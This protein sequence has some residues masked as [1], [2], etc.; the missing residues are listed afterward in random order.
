MGGLTRA[1]VAG[2]L[3]LTL[4]ACSDSSAG[5]PRRTVPPSVGPSLPAV[6]ALAL[7]TVRTPAGDDASPFNK[8]RQLSAPPG[9]KVTAKVSNPPTTYK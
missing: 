7:T 2:G 1:V 5:A 6:P 3:A 4:A 9:W 8:K